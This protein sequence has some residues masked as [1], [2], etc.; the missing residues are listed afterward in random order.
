MARLSE[1]QRSEA[2]GMLRTGATQ[3]AVARYFNC[4]R[5]TIRKLRD[6]YHNTGSVK[7]R[8]RSG[9]PKVLTQ[10]QERFIRVTHLRNRFKPVTETARQI[11]GLHG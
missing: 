5:I 2:I 3:L 7:D 11:I 6:R 4:T 10:R 1:V 8:P 9:R